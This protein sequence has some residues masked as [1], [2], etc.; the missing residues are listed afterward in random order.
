MLRLAV[1]LDMGLQLLDPV[2]ARLGL[3]RYLV[4]VIIL[5]I[6]CMDVKVAPPTT[7]WSATRAPR[8][9]VA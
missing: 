5:I 6:R 2:E 1:M 9:L 3:E 8:V 4:L 7:M